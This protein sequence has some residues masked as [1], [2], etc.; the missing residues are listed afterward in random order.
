MA[1]GPRQA[2]HSGLL[3]RRKFK[4]PLT[5]TF[6]RAISSSTNKN[7]SSPSQC[8][9]RGPSNSTARLDP[10]VFIN[11]VLVQGLFL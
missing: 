7:L 9:R 4:V 11:D 3:H 5:F 8:F 6:Y 10:D 1:A 2:I